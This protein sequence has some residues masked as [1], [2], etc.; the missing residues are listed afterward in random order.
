MA[1]ILIKN[2]ELI[3]EGQRF[4][5]DVYISEGR[6]AEISKSGINIPADRTIEAEGQLLLP[7]IIDDQVHF[8]EPG[9]THKAEI[10][11][12]A[13]AAVAGGVTSYMEMPNTIP[14]ASTQELLEQKYKRASV[15]SLANYSFFMG[16]TNDNLDE[17][18]KTDSGT[19]CG[20]KLFMG[21]STG[22]M[23]VD[24]EDTLRAI[25]SKAQ[26]LIATHCEDEQTIR[27]NTELFI[28]KYGE[29]IPFSAHPEIRNAEACHKSS[30]LA[31][32]LARE[33]NTRLHILHV[34]TARELELFSND[35]ILE[36]K[37]ITAEVCVHHLSFDDTQYSQMGSLIK[38]NPAIKSKADQNA[39]WDGLLNNKLDIIAT[40]HAPHTWEE[41]QGKYLKAPSGLPLIQHSLV[42]MLDYVDQG[43][44][45]LEFMVEKMSHAPATMF[46]IDK[47]GYIREGYWADLVLVKPGSSWQVNK[48]NI[49]YKCAWSPMEGRTFNNSVTHTIVSGHLAYEMG[50]FD[51]SRWGQRLTFNRT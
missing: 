42:L 27:S 5:A 39:L 40:D 47:R 9:L 31:V 11:T 43:K 19:V 38:C 26:L 14:Q 16:G 21:S 33:F 22:N 34:S 35:K 23:L 51:E 46:Q 15:C 28:Q 13:R 12:E 25:F 8:R 7:G 29:D 32:A 49:L 48:D 37:R 6:I 3:N 2:A 17:V 41:K 4:N 30:S 45:N 20:I 50:E 36:E 10:Y 24:N 1:S 18:L 44:L